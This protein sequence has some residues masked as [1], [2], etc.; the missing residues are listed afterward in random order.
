[1]AGDCLTSGHK[2]IG[3]FAVWNITGENNMEEEE[4]LK[5]LTWTLVALVWGSHIPCVAGDT[6]G[7]ELLRQV[8]DTGKGKVDK[9]L[10]KAAGKITG[11]S[12]GTGTAGAAASKVT[13]T[14]AGTATEKAGTKA[15]TS[16][17]ATT[18][19]ST[20]KPK[21]LSKQAE[22]AAN[23]YGQTYVNRGQQE[24]DKLMTVPKKGK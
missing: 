18:A 3:N 8:V 7:K 23:K 11:T 5:R 15:G 2:L 14:T 22:D 17:A 12:T 21:T 24:L 13:S 4:M 20:E 1:M 16:A 9:Q 10:D 6:L 19:K